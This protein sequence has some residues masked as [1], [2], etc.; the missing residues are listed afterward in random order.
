MYFIWLYPAFAVYVEAN[1]MPLQIVTLRGENIL[2]IKIFFVSNTILG[3]RLHG[4]CV[5]FFT[6]YKIII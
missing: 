6:A 2:N 4:C 5:G 3:K 1:S